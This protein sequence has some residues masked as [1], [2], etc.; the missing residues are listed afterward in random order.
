MRARRQANHVNHEEISDTKFT[1][2]T[3]IISVAIGLCIWVALA[4]SAFGHG[5]YEYA[6]CSDKD[7]RP[8]EDGYV[9]ERVDGIHVKNWG[10]L[11]PSDSRLRMSRDDK[12]HVCE[13]IKPGNSKLMCV[14]L[15][16]QGM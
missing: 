2:Y 11:H 3:L 12:D 4:A 16:P 5:W 8:V 15:K 6:C 10:V 13:Q 9:V 1:I 7:C 14:Y